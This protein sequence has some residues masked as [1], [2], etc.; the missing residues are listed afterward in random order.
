MTSSSSKR[1]PW[2]K[3]HTKESH[4][5]VLKISRTLSSQP[6]SN[7][8]EWQQKNRKSYP[9]F[10]K[11]E[12][13]AE[14]YGTILGDGF[15]ERHPRTERL[16]ISFNAEE[17]AH[18]DRIKG[19]LTHIFGKTPSLRCRNDSNCTDLSLYEK[20]IAKRLSLPLGKKAHHELRIPS[21]I[22][23]KKDYLLACLKGLFE[24]DGCWTIDKNNYTSVISFR[25]NQQ[26]LLDDVYNALIRLGY[27]PQRRKLDV[28]LARK[29]EVSSFIEKIQF[30]MY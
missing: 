10:T 9:E 21:W 23:E 1:R 8:D 2:N 29:A 25:N 4:P 28:R 24:S 27:N 5:S 26:H 16:I 18:I 14:L 20:H 19:I 15:I 3:G 22:W 6:K 7:F 13:L 17:I 11:D 30:R 12:T